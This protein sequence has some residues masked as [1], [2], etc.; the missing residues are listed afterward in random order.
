MT[1]NRLKLNSGKTEILHI[2]SKFLR[3]SSPVQA[4]QIGSEE[5]NTVS[6]ARNLGVICDSNLTMIKHVNNICRAANFALYKIGQI[7]KYLDQV[8]AAKLVHAFISSR[9]DCCNGML[10]GLPERELDKLQ[11]VQNA[12]ARM[13]ALVKKRHHI[14]PVLQ[15]LH[16]LPVR[17]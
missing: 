13:V 9:L 12:A 1:A 6:S 14:S 5:V 10:F 7:R 16:W 8:T 2:T 15:A 17:K 3:S 11:Q 4:I